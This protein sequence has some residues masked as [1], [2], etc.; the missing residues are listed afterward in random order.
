[1]QRNQLPKVIIEAQL[2]FLNKRTS[3]D[4]FKPSLI[5]GSNVLM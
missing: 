4:N 2:N 5:L 1:M 3:R